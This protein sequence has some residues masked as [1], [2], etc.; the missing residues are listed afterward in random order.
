M[1]PFDALPAWLVDELA[2]A[3]LEPRDIYDLVVA[4]L[5]E[6]LPTGVDVTSAPTIP[7]DA[8]AVADFGSRG[9]GVV[10]GLGVA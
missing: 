8:R 7:A 2:D 4:A 1:T 5:G 3:G 9:A 10:A 6:D